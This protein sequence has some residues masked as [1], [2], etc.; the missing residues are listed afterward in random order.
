MAF[1]L[2]TFRLGLMNLRL[3]LL[4]SVLTA[5]G[6]IL[7]VASVIVMSSLGEGAKR[8]AMDQIEQ[9][10]A[11]NIII[12]SMKPPETQTPQQG[13][14]SGWVSRFGLTRQDLENIRF[15]FPNVERIVP[16]KSVGGQILRNER[17]MVSQAFGTTPELIEAINLRVAR[18]R[19]LSSGDMEGEELV[20]VIGD[21]VAESLFPLEDPLNQTL[22]VDNRIFTVIGILRPVGLAAGS[23]AALVGRDL[24]LDLHIPLSTAR[25]VFGDATFRRTSGSMQNE[26]VQVSEVIVTSMSRDTVL[27][28]AE[29]LKRLL[30]VRRTGMTDVS[31]YVPYE[32]LENARKQAITYQM[33]FGSIAGIALLVGGIGIMNIMLAS[34]TERTKEIGIRRALGATKRNILMQF[35]VETGVLS[36]LG[37][38][39]GVGLGVGL[40]MLVGQ[41]VKLGNL[42]I[43]GGLAR[44]ASDLPPTQVTLW[45]IILSFSVA[46]LTGLVFG[47]Y[48]ARRAAAQDPIVALRH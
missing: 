12:R 11:R 9:L 26:E 46:V 4:R 48:P 43:L 38:L 33:V 16:L 45:S 8:A 7:G 34:V 40:S 14:R 21:K 23:G 35:L 36:T 17:R 31:A 28:D 24:H 10:G 15:N 30:E 13:N 1:F 37:G 18:G 44:G 19:Y 25:A 2:A 27:I 42:S 5:L 32:L 39:I 3:H 22:R 29:R 47:I 41:L 20:C 6:I